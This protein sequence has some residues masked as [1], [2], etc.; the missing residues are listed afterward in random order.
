MAHLTL[1]I[2]INHIIGEI[3]NVRKR[4]KRRI[5]RR[6]KKEEGGKQGKVGE[7]KKE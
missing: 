2:N 7:E 1:C 4:G 3:I 6:Q 5:N